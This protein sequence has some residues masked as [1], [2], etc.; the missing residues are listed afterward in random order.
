M[1]STSEWNWSIKCLGI[2]ITLVIN[3]L[4]ASISTYNISLFKVYRPTREFFTHMKTSSWPDKG[5]TFWLMP[6][7][8]IEQ[9]G[10]FSMPHLLLHGAF[11]YNGHLRGHLTLTTM[12]SVSQLCWHYLHLRIRYVAAWIRTPNPPPAG[13]TL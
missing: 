13:Q 12:P 6:G 7:M 1:N 11:V 10:F 4:Q 8:I 3:H 9:W 2:D 5:Y